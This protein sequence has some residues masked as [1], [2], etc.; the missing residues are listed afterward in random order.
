MYFP[1]IDNFLM[2]VGSVL[3][4]CGAYLLL[5][6][7]LTH[8]DRIAPGRIRVHP[9]IRWMVG[10]PAPKGDVHV[11][12]SSASI[13]AAPT[14]RAAATV[15]TTDDT[16]DSRLARLETQHRALAQ[17]QQELEHATIDL[18]ADVKRLDAR[19]DEVQSQTE[20]QIHEESVR[21]KDSDFRLQ[22]RG[23][24]LL[25]AGLLLS[26]YGAVFSLY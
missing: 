26:V 24:V 9:F 2:A 19:I 7:A 4:L 23:S 8:L 22:L 14:V 1:P 10:R 18:K 5:K 20:R 25:I 3:Q 6:D 13:V 17:R 16:L 21:S 12:A 11:T 15:T